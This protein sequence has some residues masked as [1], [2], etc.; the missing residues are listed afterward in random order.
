MRV[1]IFSDIHGNLPALEAVLAEPANLNCVANCVRPLNLC[2]PLTG[3]P[4]Q[5]GPLQG[6]RHNRMGTDGLTLCGVDIHEHPSTAH[7][8]G[9][10]AHVRRELVVIINEGENVV[11][12]GGKQNRTLT[13]RLSCGFFGT[14]RRNPAPRRPDRVGCARNRADFGT[15]LPD[16]LAQ[17]LPLTAGEHRVFRAALLSIVLTL[18]VGP[19]ASLLCAV[20]CHPDAASTGSCEHRDPTS[21]S[22]RSN[23]GCPDIAAG[24]AALVREEVRRGVSASDR[25]HVVVVPRFQFVPP[26]S[27]PEFGREPGQGPPLEARPLVLALRI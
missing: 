10:F 13:M 8:P 11:R 7:H 26:P 1:A 18:A 27:P 2:D 6:G 24:T 16:T 12:S 4:P 3:T 20:L 5:T 22:V 21:T 19:N 17:V 23:D 14:N 25:Q 9:R 15:S